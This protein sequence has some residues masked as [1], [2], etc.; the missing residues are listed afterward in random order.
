MATRSSTRLSTTPAVTTSLSSYL[1]GAT[2]G[3]SR[4]ES[5]RKAVAATRDWLRELVAYLPDVQLIFT[6]YYNGAPAISDGDYARMTFP[7]G[8]EVGAY[9]AY[10][11]LQGV[12]AG[13]NFDGRYPKCL[14]GEVLV[15]YANR[16]GFPYARLPE[17]VLRLTPGMSKAKAAKVIAE[18]IPSYHKYYAAVLDANLQLQQ[19]VDQRIAQEQELLAAGPLK[20]RNNNR[21]L[22]RL[23]TPDRVL[24]FPSGPHAGSISCALQDKCRIECSGLPLALA[25]QLLALVKN[26]VPAA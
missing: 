20:G 21:H 3:L 23:T 22:D 18:V 17:P 13:L 8:C 9:L 4:P 25:A 2:F 5:D 19:L 14:N 12:G 16:P 10:E 1:L 15:P 6:D 24:H 7:G 11:R 26:Y